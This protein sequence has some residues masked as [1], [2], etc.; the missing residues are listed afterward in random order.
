MRDT[1]VISI[2]SKSFHADVMTL[3]QRSL[4][5]IQSLVENREKRKQQLPPQLRKEE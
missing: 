5:T 3:N 4:K 2:S 1:N